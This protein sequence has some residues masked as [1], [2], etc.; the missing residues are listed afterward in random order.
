MWNRSLTM[1]PDSIMTRIELG[2]TYAAMN[3]IEKA[4]KEWRR[5]P[6]PTLRYFIAQG[7]HAYR[8]GNKEAAINYFR[9]A[10]LIDDSNPA[11][12]YNLAGLYWERGESQLSHDA[13]EAYLQRDPKPSGK[14]SFALGRLLLLE[15][16][17]EALDA[18]REASRL[19]PQLTH[20]HYF[21]G[22]IL[23]EQGEYEQA[24]DE[25][26]SELAVNPNLLGAKSHLCIIARQLQRAPLIEQWCN[27]VQ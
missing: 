13:L 18:F 27:G 6:T 5:Y 26:I 16:K 4:V 15:G 12:Y 24:V 1:A 21:A 20:A 25:F 14:R 8:L 3:Q 10:T 19:D 7:H 2:N 22:T 9:M 23:F 11:L 17:S